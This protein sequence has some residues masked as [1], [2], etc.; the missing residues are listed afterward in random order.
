M[1][2]SSAELAALPP[3]YSTEHTPSGEVMLHVKLFDPC[4]AWTWYIAEAGQDPHTGQ[5]I[6]WG[7]VIGHERE[8]GWFDLAELGSVRNRLGLPLERDR[9]FTPCSFRDLG[10]GR[11]LAAA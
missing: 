2:L 6:L 9:Y 8:W 11:K 7:Y 10:T 4:S 5:W 3:L 1:L